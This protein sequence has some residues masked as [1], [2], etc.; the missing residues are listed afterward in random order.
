MVLR[1]Y[2][3]LDGKAG[4]CKNFEKPQ[5]WRAERKYGQELKGRFEDMSQRSQAPLA[6]VRGRLR[7]RIRMTERNKQPVTEGA[8]L[9]AT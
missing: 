5:A 7:V 2:E 8:S 6:R 9:Q 4:Q 3:A 1:N